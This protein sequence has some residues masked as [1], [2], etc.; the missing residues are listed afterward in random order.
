VG[1]LANPDTTLLVHIYKTKFFLYDNLLSTEST[2][3]VPEAS[4]RLTVNGEKEYG[5]SYDPEKHLYR[6]D[7][8]P[9]SGDILLLKISKEGF[10][11]VS[12]ETVVKDKASFEIVQSHIYYNEN[13]KRMM[14]DGMI[15]PVDFYGSDTVMSIE[16]KI[17]D[18]ANV[19]NYYRLNVRSIG[20]D[21]TGPLGI[22]DYA[23]ANDIFTSDDILFFDKN[24][25]SSVNGWP[26]NFTNL[27][28]DSLFE[29]KE[30]TFTIVSRKRN[31]PFNWIE[32]DLQQISEEF[33][34]YLKSID[35]YHSSSKDI[36]AEPVFLFTN[37]ENGA[38]IF[39]SLTSNKYILNF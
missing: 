29:G 19:K 25:T 8:R 32:F 5:F 4:V 13:P 27:F 15:L 33:Y 2:F 18:R 22:N 11:S 21:K 12:A 7:Y 28:D 36:Y 1:A 3:I 30:Y 17:S 20:S 9:V 24:L 26:E 16:C 31:S 39:G 37:V 6:A 34:K 35:T 14:K 10:R 23:V 38:G